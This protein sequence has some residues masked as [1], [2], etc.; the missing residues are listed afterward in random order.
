MGVDSE[1]AVRVSARTLGE[2]INAIN[3]D[4]RSGIDDLILANARV[5][6]GGDQEFIN[7][8]FSA[9][10]MTVVKQGKVRAEQSNTSYYVGTSVWDRPSIEPRRASKASNPAAT[11][12]RFAPQPDC[13]GEAVPHVHLSLRGGPGLHTLC[14]GARAPG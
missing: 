13:T 2:D 3:Q 8:M 10:R 1:P 4:I 6:I 5:E 9:S 11:R 12:R 7:Q 14:N